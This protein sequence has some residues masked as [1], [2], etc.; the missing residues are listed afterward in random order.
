MNYS[1][2]VSAEKYRELQRMAEPPTLMGDEIGQRRILSFI[3][4]RE[5]NMVLKP[6]AH[7]HRSD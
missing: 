3:G 6:D 5:E 2:K 4:L 7:L 1:R